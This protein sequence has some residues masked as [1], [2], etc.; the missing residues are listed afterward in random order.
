MTNPAPQ[1]PAEGPPKKKRGG[2]MKVALVVLGIFILVAILVTAINGSDGGEST[3]PAVTTTTGSAPAPT[4]E[5]EPAPE[6]EPE[7]AEPDVPREYTNALRAADRYLSVSAFSQQGLIE[8]LKF[9]DYS[10]EAAQYA[11]ENVGADWSDQAVKKAE[12]Y[13]D[14]S[15]MSRQGLIDQLQ[16][17]KFTAEQAEY[18]ASQVY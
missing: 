10:Q 15:P 16:Y 4:S 3:D 12:Q 18:G 13:M 1:Y 9:E 2:C 7:S 6:A 11:A 14:M 5:A 8:Q 17:E